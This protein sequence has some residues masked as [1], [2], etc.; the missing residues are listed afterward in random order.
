MTSVFNSI[1][2]TLTVTKPLG[3]E[4]STEPSNVTFELYRCLKGKP[5][6]YRAVNTNN[7][8]IS[9]LAVRNVVNADGKLDILVEKTPDSG[10]NDNVIFKVQRT[11][12]GTAYEVVSV[13]NATIPTGQ[14]LTAENNAFTVNLENDFPVRIRGL[15]RYSPDRTE[16]KEKLTNVVYEKVLTS[17]IGADTFEADRNGFITIP[18][19]Y[20]LN[21]ELTAQIK[22]LPA[23][24]YSIQ[25]YEANADTVVSPSELTLTPTT[26]SDQ[27]TTLTVKRSYPK[28]YFKI[29][30][31][32]DNG[33]EDTLIKSLGTEPD[34]TPLTAFCG[35]QEFTPDA[36]GMFAVSE[37]YA[38]PN[39]DN[40]SSYHLKIDIPGLPVLPDGERYLFKQ[41]DAEGNEISPATMTQVLGEPYS[42]KVKLTLT[43]E[44]VTH[45]PETIRFKIMSGE[46]EVTKVTDETKPLLANQFLTSR[47]SDALTGS[48]VLTADADNLV[49]IINKLQ[50]RDISVALDWNDN[51]YPAVKANK[52]HYP[53]TASLETAELTKRKASATAKTIF[54]DEDPPTHRG[55]LREKTKV[56]SRS[57]LQTINMIS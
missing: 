39:A 53:I 28:V 1:T 13:T 38:L 17:E 52:M 50:T 46:N 34:T 44:N 42:E 18:R 33:T 2:E 20:A 47:R 31:H 23:G 40:T 9:G 12:D 21:G 10:E 49:T 32:T 54:P 19:S 22:G 57:P 5:Y 3:T 27:P 30:K 45:Y 35:G 15:E 6:T 25:E 8:P 51:G 48:D 55:L 26:V 37:L 36:N 56:S 24:T 7:E 16:T 43:K 11:T 4:P 14:E 29:F 41:Y